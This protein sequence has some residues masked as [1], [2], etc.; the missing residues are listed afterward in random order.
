MNFLA[1][2]EHFRSLS[3][4]YY[5]RADCCILVFDTTKSTTFEYLDLLRDEFLIEASPNNQQFPF[6]LFGNKIDLE[7]RE[8]ICLYNS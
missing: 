1:G 4:G 5:R 8:V 6:A 2:H 3:Y 7:D